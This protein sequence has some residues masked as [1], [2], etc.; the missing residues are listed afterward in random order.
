MACCMCSI[1]SGAQRRK[2]TIRNT[3]TSSNN[4]AS[5]SSSATFTIGKLIGGVVQGVTTTAAMV[6]RGIRATATAISSF[7]NVMVGG[8]GSSGL[9]SAASTHSQRVATKT[10][11]TTTSTTISPTT[12]ATRIPHFRNLLLQ[13]LL[14]NSKS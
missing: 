6:F 4:A 13:K 12:T 14:A 9:T 1:Y 3:N 11:Y 10:S 8:S 7:V 2:R 5:A